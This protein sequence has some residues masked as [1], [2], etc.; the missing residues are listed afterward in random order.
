M[1]TIW[2]KQNYFTKKIIFVGESIA[3]LFCLPNTNF[4]GRTEKILVFVRN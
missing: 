2:T 3:N 4:K 1:F